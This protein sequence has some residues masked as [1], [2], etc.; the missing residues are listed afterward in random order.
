MKQFIAD[1]YCEMLACK[2]RWSQGGRVPE[3]QSEESVGGSME[4]FS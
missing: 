4:T 1:A 2:G 3:R